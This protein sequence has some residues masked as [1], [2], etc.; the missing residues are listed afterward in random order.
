MAGRYTLGGKNG[1]IAKKL[2]RDVT[3]LLEAHHIIY[4]LGSGTL[5]GLVREK[6]L[7]PW[8][9]DV[10]IFIQD[11][12]HDKFF[13]IFHEFKK[14]GCLLKIK[15]HEKDTG[16]FKKGQARIVKIRT[17]KFFLFRGE[18]LLDIFFVTKVNKKSY[19]GVGDKI[20]SVPSYLHEELIS[21]SFEGKEYHIPKEYDQ[22]LTLRYGNW[23]I[24][25][26][27]WNT[28]EDDLALL[29]E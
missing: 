27:K 28:Y 29:K 2:L 26:K 20:M 3:H 7:L 9:N 23:R 5:L 18:V 21:F 25:L 4:W 12:E 17:R 24:P 6:R 16:I 15:H 1:V 22:Y 10:D 19:W 13:S 14:L 11:G 8:D